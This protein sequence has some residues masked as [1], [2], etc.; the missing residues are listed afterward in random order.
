MKKIALLAMTIVLATLLAGCAKGDD[1]PPVIS[2]ISASDI[3]QTSAVI[4]W[5]TDEPAT[6]Q[7]EYGLTSGYGSA[8]SLD[9]TLVTSHSVSLSELS[10]GTTYH[11]RVKS[12]DASENQAMSADRTFSTATPPD[13]TPPV[14]SE[15]GASDITTCTATIIWT[16]DEL[17]TS[18]VEYGLTTSYGSTSPLDS[19][20]V[21][22]HSVTLSGLTASTTYHYGVKSKDASENEAMSGDYTFNTESLPIAFIYS[23]DATG[24]NSYKSLLEGDGYSVTLVPMG[25]VATTDFSVYDLILVGADTYTLQY[26]WGDADSVNAID[27]SGKSIIGLGTGGACLFGELGL[28]ISYGNAWNLTESSIYVVDPTHDIFTTPYFISVPEDRIIQLYE[29]GVYCHSLYEP[30]LSPEVVLLGREPDD[31]SHYPLAQEGQYI[32]WG[33]TASPESM[34]QVGK[35]LFLNVVAFMLGAS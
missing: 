31:M 35:D 12:D 8:T 4:T 19:S 22:S 20:L 30:Y 27:S 33:F 10:A 9:S 7:V 34:T 3:A 15:I 23:T 26:D 16:T 25:D 14:I 24:A 5:T 32:L 17:A 21:T 2:E 11:Y 1:T 28:S 6:S 18:Q 29:G 13:T